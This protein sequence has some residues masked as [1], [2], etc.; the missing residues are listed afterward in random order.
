MYLKESTLIRPMGLRSVTNKQGSSSSRFSKYRINQIA[1]RILKYT[2]LY[3][4][5]FPWTI[6][7]FPVKL[8]Q[9]VGYSDYR[10]EYP[11]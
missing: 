3:L 2:S 8:I 11:Q 10:V 7:E 1:Q 6:M 4:S 5:P 9:L